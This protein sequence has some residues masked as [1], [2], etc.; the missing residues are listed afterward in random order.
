MNRHNN[1]DSLDGAFL[2]FG[3]LGLV[4]GGDTG[5]LRWLLLGS[6]L[7]G[8]DFNIK[9]LEA[10]VVLPAFYCFISYWRTR[11]GANGLC[12]WFWRR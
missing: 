4:T 8:L 9:T 7:V 2:I 10:I 6:L 5:R 12:I 3:S 11:A 1:P